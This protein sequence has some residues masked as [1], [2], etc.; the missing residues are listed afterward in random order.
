VLYFAQVGDAAGTRAESH[1]LPEGASVAVLLSKVS[2]SHERIDKLRRIIKTAVNE[3]MAGP[4]R[5][6][7]DGDTVALF[8][9]ITG[10]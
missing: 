3:E 10:G 7:K 6:L 4:N 1:M 2:E 9:P 5:V 8:P